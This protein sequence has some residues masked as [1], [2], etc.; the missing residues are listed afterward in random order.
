LA[1]LE[2][3]DFGDLPSFTRKA[4][5]LGVGADL[6]ATITWR[7]VVVRGVGVGFALSP[8]VSTPDA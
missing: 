6:P 8:T 3:P 1:R 2:E 7:L 4:V 5:Y